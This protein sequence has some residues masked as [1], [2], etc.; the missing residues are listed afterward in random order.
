MS[1]SITDLAGSVDV[2]TFKPTQD[3]VLV[4][5]LN[6]DRTS[7]GIILPKES[8][9]LRFVEV[10]AKGPGAYCDRLS[11]YEPL[12]YRPGDKLLIMD[13]AGEY[14]E[15]N[16]ERYRFV[17]S[18]GVWAKVEFADLETFSIHRLMPVM[19]KLVVKLKDQE[20]SNGGILLPDD[21]KLKW[22]HAEVRSASEGYFNTTLAQQVELGIKAGDK[23]V[24]MRYAGANIDVAGEKLRIIQKADV[25]S[26]VED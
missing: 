5:D 3:Y 11:R 22:A 16:G 10:V 9:E 2:T 24:F 26:V 21:L 23:V 17:R 4:R 19:D 1:L 15:T 12:A 13:Y 6:R 7:G 14:I 20:K 8:S 25:L 18:H